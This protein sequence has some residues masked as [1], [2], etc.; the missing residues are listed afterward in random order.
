MKAPFPPQWKLAADPWKRQI[1]KGNK[2]GRLQNLP[3]FPPGASPNWY[4]VC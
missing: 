3:Q 1:Q 2:I 4:R